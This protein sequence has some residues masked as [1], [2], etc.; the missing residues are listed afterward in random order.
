MSNLF[1]DVNIPMYAGGRA[2]RYKDACVWVMR[3]IVEGR[4]TVATD[5][6]AIQEVL[7]RYGSIGHLDTGVTMA[8]DLLDLVPVIYPVDVEDMRLATDLFRRYGPKGVTPR[9][10][11]HAAVMMGRG[12]KEIISTDAHFD[13][14][15]AITRIDPE[16]LFRKKGNK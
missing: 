3:E 1:L 2:H 10:V 15:K 4:L 9:D 11:I 16:S 13:L 6:E 14:I 7:Y 5:T 12:I 8:N